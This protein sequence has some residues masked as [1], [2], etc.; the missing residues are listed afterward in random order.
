MLG[1]SE[2]Q[3]ERDREVMRRF[4][5]DNPYPPYQ[6]TCDKMIIEQKE[7]NQFSECGTPNHKWMK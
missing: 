2:K 7:L 3:F 4:V 5:K 1:V 6:F